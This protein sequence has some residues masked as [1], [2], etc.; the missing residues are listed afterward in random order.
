MLS[1]CNGAL[2][3]HFAY[4]E[5][6]Y[7]KRLVD[8]SVNFFTKVDERY[9]RQI[10]RVLLLSPCGSGKTVTAFRIIKELYDQGYRKVAFIA[11]RTKLLEQATEYIIKMNVMDD[12]P[13]L[14]FRALSIFEKDFEDMMNPDLVIFDECHHSVCDSGIYLVEHLE[15]TKILGLTAT[16]WRTDRIKLLFEK[17]VIDYGIN[18][19]IEM[20]Y[21]AKFDHYLIDEWTAQSVTSTYIKNTNLFGKSVMYFHTQEESEIAVGL[22]KEAGIKAASLYGHH[23]HKEREHLYEQFENGEITVVCNLLLLTEGADFPDLKS[24]FIKPSIKGLTIQMGGRGLRLHPD[25]SHANIVQV[26][27]DGFSFL[28]VAKSRNSFTVRDGKWIQTEFSQEFLDNLGNSTLQYKL[29]LAKDIKNFAKMEIKD[30]VKDSRKNVD[31][32]NLRN[33]GYNRVSEGLDDVAEL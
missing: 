27:G 24:V 20:G 25:K 11:H 1:S 12:C 26:K 13:D 2:L 10:D 8:K 28:R 22:L 29:S 31:F 14:K 3:L 4:Q 16:N 15:A 18:S 17:I 6:E 5:R 21:L 33:F 30:N 7:Q 23:T 32:Q 19:L 9:G